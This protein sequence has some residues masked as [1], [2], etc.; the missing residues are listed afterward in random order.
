MTG[1]PDAIGTPLMRGQYSDAR[2]TLHCASSRTEIVAVE[3]GLPNAEPLVTISDVPGPVAAVHYSRDG[4]LLVVAAGVTGLRGVAEIRDAATGR[5]VRSF[6]GHRDLVYDA[7]LSPDETMLATAGYDRSIKLW[8]VADGTLLRSIDVHNGAVFDLA[9]H[10][11]GKVLGSASAD[12][13]PADASTGIDGQITSI[14]LDDATMFA[15]S[16]DPADANDD[17]TTVT[18]APYV[19]DIWCT[20]EDAGITNIWS[21]SFFIVGTP[22]AANVACP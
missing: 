5:L 18:S 8:N 9:W 4:S 13:W 3:D 12:D 22:G 16:P 10:P 20:A 15:T 7:E 14:Q 19:D 6:G 1:Y 11:S 17:Y 2:G 21:A